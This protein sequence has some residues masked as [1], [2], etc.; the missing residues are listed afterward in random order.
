MLSLVDPATTTLLSAQQL[1]LNDRTHFVFADADARLEKM[2][3]DFGRVSAA[4]SMSVNA[5]SASP[6][7]E[8][9]K[10]DPDSSWKECLKSNKNPSRGDPIFP[11]KLYLPGYAESSNNIVR[12]RIS[13]E[14][15]LLFSSLVTSQIRSCF[16]PTSRLKAI[17]MV[18]ALGLHL[19]D[20]H[21]LDR[22]VPYLI[23]LISDE[24]SLV[25][26]TALKALTQIL[27]STDSLTP[28]DANIFPEYILPSLHKLSNDPDVLVRTTY[29]LCISSLAE[30][31]LKFLELS[32]MFKQGTLDPD[33]DTDMYL[34][35]YDAALRDLHELV[36][37][38][39]VALLIDA[40]PA[41]KRALLSEMPRLCIFFGRQRANDVLLGHMITSFFESIVG[42]GTFVGSRSLEEYIL[43]LT[44]QALT[45]SEEFVVEKVLSALRALGELGLIQKIKLKELVSLARLHLW[46]H[47]LNNVKKPVSRYLDLF[48]PRKNAGT[49]KDQ[50]RQV[51]QT[52]EEITKGMTDEDKEKLIAL[53]YY[54]S[55]SA[56]SFSR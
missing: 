32:Q 35:T 19:S 2:F 44:V 55:K 27:S 14:S 53:R 36:Q 24:M 10:P 23:T 11:I 25:R 50:F 30:S 5:D 21:R 49:A 40:N 3:V 6:S 37:E 20:D 18:L 9:P 56:Q 39:V 7:N 28:S 13:E 52:R 42:V 43:P 54:I 29:A 31:A 45:D 26:A 8:T 51:I 46:R 12:T 15:C 38:E 16:L 4:L 34:V 33:I 41:V 47:V 48:C 1:L 22:I 17:D